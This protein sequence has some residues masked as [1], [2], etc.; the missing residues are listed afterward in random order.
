MIKEFNLDQGCASTHQRVDTDMAERNGMFLNSPKIDFRSDTVTRPTPGMID[1]ICS[2]PV[3]DDVYGDDPSVNRLEEEF[4]LTIGKERSVFFPSGTQSNLAAILAHC[5]RGDEMIVGDMYHTYGFEAGGASALG[6]ISYRALPT[7]ADGSLN[8]NAIASNIKPDDPHY[9]ET[10]LLC[11]E[12][13]VSGS[14]IPLVTLKDC[15]DTAHQYGLK[16]H[17]D[18]ARLFNA[19][20]ELGVPVK[21]LAN[22]ADTVSVCLS[23]GLG[24]PAGT[25][26][27]CS[28][29]MERSIRRNRKMLG[30]GMRQAGLLAAAG[31]YA[32][33]HHV[34]RLRE[35]HERA[36]KLAAILAELADQRKVAVK[37]ST[38]M[39]FVKPD[40]KDHQPLREHLLERGFLVTDKKPVFRFVMHL[41]LDDDDIERFGAAIVEYFNS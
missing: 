40:S 5:A 7:E 17:L 31:I 18:G 38:N 29:K 2:A 14:A 26:L 36:R 4:A 33:E 37:Q 28:R 20:I 12:N 30:G 32:L 24:A 3:G 11:L 39:V 23:K 13:T 34:D 6:G 1:A 21:S 25:L 10:R 27:G 41:G 19:A 9:P 8:K 15:A 16:V 22:T 35:D